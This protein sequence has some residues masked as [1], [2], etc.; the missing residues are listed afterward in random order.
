MVLSSHETIQFDI[1]LIILYELL[2]SYHG[3]KEFAMRTYEKNDTIRIPDYQVV[4]EF[5]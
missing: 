5:S 2:L 4:T 1:K 3:S